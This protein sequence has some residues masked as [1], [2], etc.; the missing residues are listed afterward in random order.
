MNLTPPICLANT[1]TTALTIN[2]LQTLSLVF[3]TSI[4]LLYQV[5]STLPVK[6]QVCEVVS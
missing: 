2:M 3:N 6:G 5:F 4:I 1:L